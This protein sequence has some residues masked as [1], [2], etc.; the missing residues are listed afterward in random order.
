MKIEATKIYDFAKRLRYSPSD[1]L[2]NN[3]I[4]DH[5]NKEYNIK[6]IP[7]Y[8]LFDIIFSITILLNFIFIILPLFFL[9]P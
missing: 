3:I 8:V 1:N 5:V 2:P 9:F 6:A 7:Y 4:V